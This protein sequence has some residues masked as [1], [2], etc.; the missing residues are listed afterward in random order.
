LQQMLIALYAK[1]V[2]LE[3]QIANRI[4]KMRN[5]LTMRRFPIDV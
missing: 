2:K 3:K 5:W 1:Q 4:H